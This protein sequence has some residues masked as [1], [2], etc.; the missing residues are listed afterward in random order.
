VPQQAGTVV[1][2]IWHELS[3][4][5]SQ[6]FTQILKHGAGVKHIIVGMMLHDSMAQPKKVFVDAIVDFRLN[7]TRSSTNSRSRD[8]QPVRHRSPRDVQGVVQ[9]PESVSQIVHW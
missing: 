3:E 2:P 1:V 4:T 6:I 9:K 8:A 7:Q 5:D